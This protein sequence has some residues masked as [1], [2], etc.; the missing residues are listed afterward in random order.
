MQRVFISYTHDSE[1]HQKRVYALADRLRGDGV[2]V[3]FDRDCMPGW[4]TRD[5]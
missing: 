1:E 5:G 2:N 3:V 4:R